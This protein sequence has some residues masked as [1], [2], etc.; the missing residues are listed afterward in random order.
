MFFNPNKFIEK[1]TSLVQENLGLSQR[2]AKHELRKIYNAADGAVDARLKDMHKKAG[3]VV[4]VTTLL[5]PALIALPFAAVEKSYETNVLQNPVASIALGTSLLALGGIF[6]WGQQGVDRALKV[7]DVRSF[8]GSDLLVGITARRYLKNVLKNKGDSE[9][10]L[11]Q[12][13]R[14]K[15]P[16]GRQKTVPEKLKGRTFGSRVVAAFAPK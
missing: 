2:R 10:R 6:Y 4:P 15:W 12:D 14:E 3:K 9:K 11:T 16:V 1:N 13:C 8:P 7:G 5:S